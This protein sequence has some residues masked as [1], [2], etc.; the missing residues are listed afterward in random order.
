MLKL[1]TALYINYT[2]TKI[3]NNNTTTNKNKPVMGF[4]NLIVE[5][6]KYERKKLY[7]S[8]GLRPEK[9]EVTSPRKGQKP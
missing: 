2:P 4:S 8:L 9:A 3:K 7:I 5:P 6:P 1:T